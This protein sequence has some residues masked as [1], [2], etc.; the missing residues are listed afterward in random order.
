[1]D[2]LL[3][4]QESIDGILASMEEMHYSAS[5]IEHYRCWYK[6]FLEYCD[7]R[8]YVNYSEAIGLQYLEEV[9]GISITSLADRGSYNRK[10]RDAVRFQL[11]LSSYSHNRIFTQRFHPEHKRL[12][13]HFYWNAIYNRYL[14]YLQALNYKKNTIGHKEL[15]VRTMINTFISMGLNDLT[16]VDQDAVNNAVS[17]FIHFQPSVIKSRVQDMQQFFEF[18]FANGFTADNKCDLIP[19]INTPHVYHLPVNLPVESV[20]KMLNSIDRANTMGKRDYAILLL[21]TRL[22]NMK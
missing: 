12:P 8:G 2:S 9:F 21:A 20:K 10:L 18:C 19:R 17:S 22:D 14:C 15:L 5:T 1:M 11:L 4:I 3:S 7:A 6:R 13:E 16:E